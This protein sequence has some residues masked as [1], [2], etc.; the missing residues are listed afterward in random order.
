[1][2]QGLLCAN[3]VSALSHVHLV[4]LT[5]EWP[6]TAWIRTLAVVAPQDGAGPG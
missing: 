4:I 5:R 3:P 6:S 2:R 1:M